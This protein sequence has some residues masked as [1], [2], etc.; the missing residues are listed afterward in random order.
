[1]GLW[2]DV[3]SLLGFWLVFENAYPETPA[4]RYPQCHAYTTSALKSPIYCE[5][6]FELKMAPLKFDTVVIHTFVLE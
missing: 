4:L 3:L 1:M 6:A 2:L 5:V